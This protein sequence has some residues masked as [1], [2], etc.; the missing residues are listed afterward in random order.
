MKISNLKLNRIL[1]IPT[2]KLNYFPTKQPFSLKVV[3]N[4]TDR[5]KYYYSDANKHTATIYRKNRIEALKP[6]TS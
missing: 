4:V 6:C 3:L 5:S 2:N 1:I